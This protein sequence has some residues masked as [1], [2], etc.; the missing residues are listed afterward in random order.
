MPIAIRNSSKKS[1][2]YSS[3]YELQ[4][5]LFKMQLKL[6][7]S[8]ANTLIRREVHMGSCIPD[9]IYV[10]FKQVPNPHLWPRKFANRHCFVLWWLRNEFEL[11][12]EEIAAR[13]YM[14]PRGIVVQT[15]NELINSGAV[16]TINS[17]KFA[18]STE[19]K[20]VQAEVVAVEAKLSNWK[21]AIQQ[22][23]DYLNF[24]D[25][26]FVAMDPYQMPKKL[27][28]LEKFRELGIGLCAILPEKMDWF[29]FPQVQANYS[30][31]DREFLIASAGSLSHQTLWSSR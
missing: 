26:V 30:G 14:P 24:A 12:L 1:R 4:L 28:V 8:Y 9:F 2:L 5:D 18:L 17:G 15:I 27:T 23:Q 31:V 11:S 10:S 20:T 13:F 3:E 6:D 21:R 7:G 25:K 16:Q 19:M 29:V 22:A